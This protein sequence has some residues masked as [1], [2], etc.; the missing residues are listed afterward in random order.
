MNCN[1]YAIVVPRGG[2]KNM[3]VIKKKSVRYET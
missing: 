3:V 1:F 2:Y